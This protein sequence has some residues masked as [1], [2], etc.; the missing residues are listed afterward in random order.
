M[1]EVHCVLFTSFRMQTGALTGFS[2]KSLPTNVHIGLQMPSTPGAKTV[3]VNGDYLYFHYGCDGL[4]DRGWGCGYRTV[5]TLASWLFHNCDL[6]KGRHMLAPSLPDMQ[7]ALVSLGDKPEH[8]SGSRDWIGTVEAALVLDYFYEVPCKIAHL[9]GHFERQG[10][11]VM[12]G[13]GADNSSKG[14]LGVC[15][16]EGHDGSS[17]LIVDPH[18]YGVQR[19]RAELQRQAWVSWT[20]ISSLD[21]SSFYNLCLPQTGNIRQTLK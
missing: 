11:P 16:A 17:L 6:P 10:S 7:R 5:Q 8:F 19:D 3:T 9:R 1:T 14:V 15:S 12:M 4:D 13:G 18:Y 21:H 2:A 20:R